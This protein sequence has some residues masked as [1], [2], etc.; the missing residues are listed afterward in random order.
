MSPD[1]SPPPEAGASS[2]GNRHDAPTV[3]GGGLDHPAH[4]RIEP[5]TQASPPV[6]HSTPPEPATIPQIPPAERPAEA[7]DGI[8]A[9]QTTTRAKGPEILTKEPA[10]G[11]G[12]AETHGDPRAN[13]LGQDRYDFLR[14]P[15]QQGELGWLG[16]YR[17]LKVL[18]TGGMGIV[19]QAEDPRLKRPIALKVMKP[20]LAAD[21]AARRRFLHEAQA[22]AA[23]DHDHVLHI[24]Q[25]G[26]DGEVPF[27][28]M[29]Y[30]NGENLEERLQREQKLP[31]TLVLRI[32]REIAEGLEAAHERG[33]I[34]RDIKPSNIWLEVDHDRV[35]ILD[36]GLARAVE[37]SNPQVQS[38]IVARSPELSAEQGIEPLTYPG[39]VLGT[40]PYMAPEQAQGEV[41]DFRCDLFSLGCVLYRLCTGE[42]AFKGTNR[43]AVLAALATVD[44]SPPHDKNH[45]VPPALSDLVMHLLAKQPADRPPQARAVVETI[46][47][48]EHK[49]AKAREL[50]IRPFGVRRRWLAVAA[51][52]LFGL[53]GLVGYFFGSTIIRI[54]TN[55]GELVVHVNDPTVQIAVKQNGVVVQDR[56]T[57]REFVLK[58]GEG[59]LE[60]YE[61]ASG[62]RLT[63]R[64]FKLTRGGKTY[65]SVTQE[66][67]RARAGR[68]RDEKPPTAPVNAVD[69]ERRAAE[70]GMAI[71][72][73]VTI[74]S[75]GIRQTIKPRE[76]EIP[77]GKLK[78]VRIWRFEDSKH[79][80]D[81]DLANVEGLTSL[82]GLCLPNAGISDAGMGY[83]RKLTNLQTLLLGGAQVSDSG[84]ANLKGLA[85][86][87]QLSLSGAKLSDA[88]LVH[89]KTMT[90]LRNL[91]LSDTQIGDEGLIH[92]RSL[93]SLWYLELN[94]TRVG[95]AGLAHLKTL[96][97]LGGLHLNHTRVGDAGL[98]HLRTL[99]S[100]YTLELKGTLVTDA[101]LE[102]LQALN[103]QY[104]DL[105]D[106]RVG[107]TG[108]AYIQTQTS[109]GSLKL[110]AT[111]VSDT[112]LARLVKTLTNL[113]VLELDDSQ[114]SDAGL[115]RLHGL[116]KLR[117]LNLTG[118]KV[119]ADGVATL[120]KVL[121]NCRVT[122]GPE[123]R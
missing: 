93:P 91:D 49:Q 68:D 108:M 70:W 1:N 77:T 109:L 41:V 111:Q 104:L 64:Q 99:T 61:Q 112:G 13:H 69:S 119:T 98:A 116:T 94:G 58:A 63:T 92:L 83:L 73:E 11:P 10:D 5:R 16:P 54:T 117:R 48:I 95:D 89:L 22:A 79:I 121:P 76:T 118:T 71:R 25:V 30:L 3:K 26:E 17:V 24:Y 56:T 85:K 52:V 33:L 67:A 106:T 7:F 97:R 110:S 84:I 60:V 39:M 8:Q 4:H 40:P 82:E 19:F 80:T 90:N 120:L 45:E 46:K 28:A 96:T 43:Q 103:L 20:F 37:G 86:L 72:A 88:G 101:G 32:G 100:L 15:Q 50:Q 47:A 87:E 102:H 107:D 78:V 53:L 62:L 105:S 57:Q 31:M 6:F 36:F 27:L 65:V 81:V 114:V 35:N 51:A 12:Y 23:I 42:N 66:V 29:Q 74:I 75:G 59:E 34:H 113:A 122:F 123:K 21:P 44:P 38:G 115:E 2:P 55:K 14:P 18:G 9:V